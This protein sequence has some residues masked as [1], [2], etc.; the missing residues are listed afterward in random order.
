MLM[1][2]K[3][4]SPFAPA[5]SAYGAPPGAGYNAFPQEPYSQAP[6]AYQQAPYNPPASFSGAPG[7][8]YQPQYSPPTQYP[9]QTS[10]A[11]G[12]YPPPQSYASP[13]PPGPFGGYQQPPSHTPPAPL[14]LPNRPPGLPAPPGL[15][16]RPSFVPPAIPSHQMQQLHQ[17]YNGNVWNGNGNDQN[18]ATSSNYSSHGYNGG[19]STNHADDTNAGA[20]VHDSID[21]M[22]A[23]TIAAADAK[24]L[25]KPAP[26]IEPAAGSLTPNLVPAA[27]IYALPPKVVEP[28]VKPETTEKKPKKEKPLKMVYSDNEVSIEEKMAMLPR[29]AFV[30]DANTELVPEEA[31]AVTGI[32]GTVDGA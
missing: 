1:I 9:A 28:E 19:T 24:A 11:P 8:S 10:Y 25:N 13:P 27:Q 2:L 15:P 32:A 4:G 6:V 5:P 29:Y 22:I 17:P 21:E 18:A 31:S 7:Q 30:P 16:Q 26:A 14:G 3:A 12:S 23:R 20:K